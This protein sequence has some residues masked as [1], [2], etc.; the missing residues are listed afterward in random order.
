MRDTI[1]KRILTICVCAVLAAL[2]FVLAYL[3]KS[4]FGRGPLRV[5]IENV[6]VFIAS[7]AY[8]PVMGM[9]VGILAD[10]L[11]CIVSGMAPIPLIT[12]GAALIGLVSGLVF[13]FVKVKPV[14]RLSIGVV[15]GHI[16]GS[17]AVKTAALYGFYGD[18]VFFRIPVY[19]GISAVEILILALLFGRKSVRQLIDKAGGGLF[20]DD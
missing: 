7:A 19:I 2:S 11:S 13:R 16:A 15:S 14:P 6:P 20:Y 8:G 3:A 17:M 18:V 5:T 10:L 9:I 1:R 12:V 4:I